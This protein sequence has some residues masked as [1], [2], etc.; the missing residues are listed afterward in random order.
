MHDIYGSEPLDKEELRL[1]L[2]LVSLLNEAIDESAVSMSDVVTKF[3]PIYVPNSEN[4]LCS[5]T[6]L[7]YNE[8]D[9]QWL[10]DGGQQVQPAGDRKVV[11]FSHPM[12]PYAISKQLGVNTRRQEVL[13]K[14]SR[15]IPFGQREPLTKRLKRILSSY[16]CDKEILK[17]LLQNADDAGATEIQFI[18]DQRQHATERIFDQS[19]RPLQGPAL[20]VYN[21]RPFTE[22]DLQGIQQLG[23]GSKSVDPNKTGQYGV[24]FNCVYH[25]TDA[26]SFLTKG[27]EIGETLCVFDPHA[28]FVPGASVEEPGRRYDDI[29]QLR[30]IFTD[31]FPCYLEEFFDLT[32]ATMFRF[33]LRNDETA[34]DS[35]LS[36]QSVS[37]E[38]VD[39]LFSRFRQ[40]V[41]DCLLFVNNVTT[42]SLSEIN[43]H[44]KKLTNSY[45]VTVEMSDFDQTVR[46]EFFEHLHNVSQQIESGQVTV[47]QITVKEVFYKITLSDN[48]GYH[49]TWLISQRVGVD[50]GVKVPQCINDAVRSRDLALLPRGGVAALLDV[51]SDT[52][53][54][55]RR[56]SKAFCFLPL[57]LKTDLPVH[58]NGHFALDHEARR[59]LW[60]DDDRG[61]KT[62]WNYMLLR[63][64][65]APAYVTLLR[66]IPAYLSSSVI[67]DNV[68]IMD[69]LGDEIP[70]LDA[71]S[72]LFPLLNKQTVEGYWRALIEA[73][74]HRIHSSQ[75]VVLPVVR[76][77]SDNNTPL[78]TTLDT[79]ASMQLE[80]EWISTGGDGPATKPFFDNLTETF[81]RSTEDRH[82]LSSNPRRRRSRSAAKK[83]HHELLRQVLLVCGL[84]I[85]RLPVQIYESFQA[86]GVDVRCVSP[87]CVIDFFALFKSGLSSCGLPSLPAEISSTPFGTSVALKVVHDYCSQD[88]AYFRSNLSGLPLLL[89]EDGQLHQ[90]TSRDRVFLS[91]H[92][93][94]LPGL[95]SMFIHHSY[96]GTIFKDVD[97]D[98]CDV[99]RRFDVSAFA[100]Y[101]SNVLPPM[102]FRWKVGQL[103]A[104]WRKVDGNS[105]V[106]N[107]RWLFLVWNFLREEYERARSLD[108]TGSV[109]EVAVAKS[110]LEPLKDW[111]LIPAF[112]SRPSNLLQRQSVSSP[113]VPFGASPEDTGDHFLVPLALAYTVLDYS[114]TSFMSYPI[115]HCFNRIGIPELNCSLL[116]G[117]SSRRPIVP[118]QNQVGGSSGFA[119]LLVSS[120][121]Q[122]TAVLKALEYLLLSGPRKN[123][124][125][126]HLSPD[127]CV[128]VLKYFEDSIDLWQDDADAKRTLR[129]LPVH[130]TLHGVVTSLNGRKA[131]L[132][133]DDMPSIGMEHWQ[134]ATSVVLLRSYMSLNKLYDVLDCPSVSLTDIYSKF[135]FPQFDQLPP[136][137][138]QT[139]LQFIK[140]VKLPQLRGDDR[141]MFISSLRQLA[142]LPSSD[143]K[144]H[145]ACQF[146]D[147]YHQV[148]K[149]MLRGSTTAFPPAPFSDFNWLEFLRLSGLQTELSCDLLVEFAQQIAE[150]AKCAGQ[151]DELFKQSRTLVG[152]LFKMPNLPT[153]GV[154]DRL[155]DISFIPSCKANHLMVKIHPGF[156]QSRDATQSVHYIKFKEGTPEEHEVLVWTSAHLL[157]DWANPYKLSEH[158]VTINY[159]D[160]DS[161][162]CLDSYRREIARLLM[163]PENP[164]INVV[165]DH[166][167]NICSVSIGKSDDAQEVRGYMK[168]EVMTGIYKFLQSQLVDGASGMSRDELQKVLHRLTEIPCIVSEL[169]QTFV[170]PRQLVISL[171]DEDQIYPYL[172]M[173]P[174]EL[175]EFKRLFLYL[176]ATMT[177]TA[178]QY[179]MV[180]E[181][182]YQHTNGEKLHPNE[183]RLAFKAVNGLFTT[184]KKHRHSDPMNRIHTL[185]LP[186]KIGHLFRSTDIIFNDEAGYSDRIRYLGRPFLVDLNECWLAAENHEDTVKLLPQ[187]L[188]PAMLSSIV[189]E[190]LED[191]SRDSVV[192]NTVAEKLKYQISSRPFAQGLLR[193]IRHEHRRSG[194]RVRQ[195]VLEAIEQHLRKIHVYGADKV[196]TYL[197]YEGQRLA[198]SES[199]CE[200]FI[201]KK[202][203]EDSGFETWNIYINK[204]ICL[205]EELQVAVAEVINRM[206]GFLLKNSV[207]Y[208]QPILSCAPH[209]IAKVLDR[210]K[211]RPDHSVGDGHQPTLPI[212]GSF[213]PIEDHHLLKEDFEEFEM[214]EYVGYELDDDESGTPIIIYAI[215]L[216]RIEEEEFY[217]IRKSDSEEH[218]AVTLRKFTQRYRINIG[219]DRQSTLA[220]AT[221][222]YKF[223]RVDG[224]VSRGGSVS[225]P[226]ARRG[227]FGPIKS[228]KPNYRESFYRS[229]VFEPEET[230]SPS[231]K[232]WERPPADIF[233]TPS[234]AENGDHLPG[235]NVGNFK[236]PDSADRPAATN[237]QPN[238]NVFDFTTDGDDSGYN[239]RHQFTTPPRGTNVGVFE[240]I[241]EKPEF[242]EI[243]QQ[244]QSPRFMTGQDQADIGRQATSEE[245]AAGGNDEEQVITT[246]QV[247]NDVSDQLEEAWKLPEAQRKKVIKRLLL[248]W[249]PDKNIGNEEFATIIVQHIQAEIERLELGLPRPANFD[250]GDFDFDPR[251]P[252]TSSQSFQQNFASAYKFFFEQMNQRAKEHREQRER[253]QENFSREYSAGGR[254]GDYNFD[255]PPTFSSVNPQPAQAK[256]FLRQAQEDLRAADNDY[257]AQDPAF[258]W[259]CFKAHQA[260]EKA[261]KAAQFAV[262]AVTSFSHDL[263]TLAASLEDLELRRLAQKLQKIVGNSNKL[264]NPDPID[265]V[266]IPHEEY[267]RE[268]ACDAVMCAVDV[269]ERVKEFV[270]LRDMN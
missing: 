110:V 211:I 52:E 268:M 99:F 178:E 6:D 207:H 42:I 167:H 39:Q 168:M 78:N 91:A 133:L 10:A 129:T 173:M 249:H 185:Y 195:T 107:D 151:S 86:A 225:D 132:M 71:Y 51:S 261:L 108:S 257:D 204:S 50:C 80:V 162:H 246:E 72:K 28:K 69:S 43:G 229:S 64:V 30:T 93:E 66:R 145:K 94:V 217:H 212:P 265:F 7:C 144:L 146:F 95:G 55:N 153:L 106:P 76:S 11:S 61:T 98:S 180:L 169:G 241:D 252:F 92:H 188:R 164:P 24:G 149:I 57:P 197:S 270:E 37:M 236:T 187:R 122:P 233:R 193:L 126:V 74:Y 218:A 254:G 239:T 46:K 90:F 2:Q 137:A 179:A 255:V 14:H 170:R 240:N 15:G 29:A 161:L 228:P 260:A 54:S 152:H 17:E 176:G 245:Q 105:D 166:I 136:D 116:D 209:A 171:Y 259:A 205:N 65:I 244:P 147:P 210:L 36:D 190:V 223:H 183:L 83:P 47:G 243:P 44:S 123:S 118:T 87:R 189:Q 8:P 269:L 206:T 67:S 222:L 103:A 117:L 13:R 184:L 238:G 159:A 172:N 23:Q 102:E 237:G 18:K 150:T 202:V 5:A 62:E 100:S 181:S 75:E 263:V 163:V 160:S 232:P 31:V 198:D 63:E 226:M 148:F 182:M 73:V 134:N 45:S 203:D 12:I 19:W 60:Q 267:T 101:L 77:Y 174:T 34:K 115:R 33:P 230:A 114:Q 201:D 68:S 131:F 156:G 194:H 9:C 104:R 88:V 119:K 234:T 196:V 143:G 264:Y 120:L 1:A 138:V 215:I 250:N 127:E 27:S 81:S 224:F 177:A 227:S 16:P 49:E 3:G 121:E 135:V 157:P 40:E 213:I 154:L 25:L 84:K 96:I 258:E 70:N 221:D 85:V 248:K 140:D 113:R 112:I 59:N 158:D 97:I 130:L 128:V 124:K 216:E 262:D 155:V 141:A 220:L 235:R 214:G 251:N 139:H 4:I 142:F 38:M 208:I 175:G 253:Y 125:I 186:T 266:V 82:S 231:A 242:T 199:E 58:I 256:R 53:G 191:R 21:N 22:A 79:T 165:V 247:M 109:S 41:F 219:D 26:P 200:C 56:P 48:E 32:N 192:L 111:C 89:C 20:C 35:E